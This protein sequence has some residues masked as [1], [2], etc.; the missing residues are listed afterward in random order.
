MHAAAPSLRAAM[1]QQARPH[2]AP[3]A[4]KQEQPDSGKTATPDPAPRS[5]WRGRLIAAG[6]AL[7]LAAGAYAAGRIQGAMEVREVQKQAQAQREKLE[8]TITSLEA[9]LEETKRTRVRLRAQ[10]ELY[11]ARAAV[12]ARNFGIA[13]D[14]IRSAAKMLAKHPAA[15]NEKIAELISKL[16]TANVVTPAKFEEQRDKVDAF[17]TQLDELL[18]GDA[19]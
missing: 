8:Q 2:D 15:K 11:R 4:S 13:Q 19:S 1:N 10:L 12:E 9:D 18:G 7:V 14:H 3:S 16:K 17:A 6:I 5:P